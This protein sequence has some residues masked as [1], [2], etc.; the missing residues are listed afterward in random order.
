MQ[1]GA[2]SSKAKGRSDWERMR[3]R[4]CCM[5]GES[6]FKADPPARPETLQEI[7]SDAHPTCTKV[8]QSMTRGPRGLGPQVILIMR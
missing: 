7:L 5:P 1:S 2:E 6:L 8:T 3:K 4:N